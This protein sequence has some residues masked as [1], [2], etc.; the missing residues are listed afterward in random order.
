MVSVITIGELQS[1]LAAVTG[2]CCENE[3]IAS[4]KKNISKRNLILFDL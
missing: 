4:D 1:A 3:G 2:N